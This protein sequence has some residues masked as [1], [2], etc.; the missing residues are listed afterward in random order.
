[1][2]FRRDSCS[3]A[4]KSASVCLRRVS[5]CVTIHANSPVMILSNKCADCNWMSQQSTLISGTSTAGIPAS[6]SFYFTKTRTTPQPQIESGQFASCRLLFA[7]TC[8][9]FNH[10]TI[11]PV[12]DM[13]IQMIHGGRRD[14]IDPIRATSGSP[15]QTAMETEGK[16]HQVAMKDWA[17]GKRQ[18]KAAAAMP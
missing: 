11:N 8:P 2:Y 10:E 15:L 13:L 1:M 18:P 6:A 9:Y 3:L 16:K 17:A 14:K 5:R 12:R 4:A 7:K